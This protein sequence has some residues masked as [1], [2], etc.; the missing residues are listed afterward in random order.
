M[1]VRLLKERLRIAIL[2]N[3]GGRAFGRATW[4][5]DLEG[6]VEGERE[7]VNSSVGSS[8]RDWA[9]DARELKSQNSKI[10]KL[11]GKRKWSKTPC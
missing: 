8:K 3:R 9:V 1:P 11:H 2:E 6:R 7:E 4:D 5:C 10:P